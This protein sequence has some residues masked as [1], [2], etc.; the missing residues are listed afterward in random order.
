MARGKAATKRGACVAC[1]AQVMWK[2]VPTAEKERNN[3][4]PWELHNQTGGGHSCTM[5]QNGFRRSSGHREEQSEQ[6]TVQTTTAQK[7][8]SLETVMTEHVAGTVSSQDLERIKSE[9]RGE[10]ITIL[11]G[12]GIKQ[13][14]ELIVR[15]D[16]GETL[17]KLDDETMHPMLTRVLKL[18][19]RGES[20]YLFGPAGS[21]KTF[22]ACQIARILGRECIVQTMPGVTAGKIL[23]FVDA[24]GREVL[25]AF[26]KAFVEGHVFV[27]DEFDRTI[28]SV[29][30]AFNSALANRWF[31]VGNQTIRAHENF[32]FI[33]TG[34][35]DMRGAT[36]QYTAAQPLD[37]STAARFAFIHWG[38]D[39]PTE[40]AIVSKLLPD[41]HNALLDRGRKLRAALALDKV[42]TVWSGPREMEKIALDLLDGATMR[43]AVNAWVWRGYPADAVAKYEARYPLPRVSVKGGK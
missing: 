6:T 7:D 20:I 1:G 14:K 41:G 29:A 19:A 17:S 18:A 30:A 9:I 35:T 34:N 4:S 15:T 43:E 26:I 31:T 3:R 2:A 27:A 40:T 8:E 38:Y 11:A 13:Q 12:F 36:R 33:A 5:W 22:G 25:T 10:I 28:P 39:E 37:L 21:G 23:G 24:G 32:V 16:K 42:D